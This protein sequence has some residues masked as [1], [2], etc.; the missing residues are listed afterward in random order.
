[1]AKTKKNEVVDIKLTYS[2]KKEL[3]ELYYFYQDS[4][5]NRV[6]FTAEERKENKATTIKDFKEKF[7]AVVKSI[8]DD[9]KT[10]EDN[11]IQYLDKLIYSDNQR[12]FIADA[13]DEGLDIDYGYSGR[14]MYG[15]Y[16]PA[17]RCDSHNDLHTKANTKIDSMGKGIVIYAE[18]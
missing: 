12:R 14:G 9:Y 17:V 5:N 7:P 4:L 15:D 13:E 8:C 16:C 11:A 10:D 1:M 3:R 18:Y 2:Q 6:D